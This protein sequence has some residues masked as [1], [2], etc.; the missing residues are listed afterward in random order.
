MSECINI[1]LLKENVIIEQHN[2]LKTNSFQNQDENESQSISNL[3]SLSSSSK[4]KRN[5]FPRQKLSKKLP[6]IK[7]EIEYES[8]VKQCAE[9][10]IQA[11]I[12][13]NL[14]NLK[15]YLEN[16]ASANIKYNNWSLLHYACSMIEQTHIDT[17]QHLEMIRLLL[18]NGAQINSQDDECWTPLH[19]ACHLGI[20]RVIS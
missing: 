19:L 15:K 13:C 7:K 17:D 18:E 1:F 16:G 6:L 11:I 8:N 20:T 12:D 2:Y 3:I 9:R 4:V 10:L 14:S 5:L